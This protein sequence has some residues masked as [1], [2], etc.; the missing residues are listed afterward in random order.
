MTACV[1]IFCFS[2]YICFVILLYFLLYEMWMFD[3]AMNECQFLKK[4]C[5]QVELDFDVNLPKMHKKSTMRNVKLK[6]FFLL[7]YER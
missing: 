6:V 2:S 4:E 7:G 3:C 1:L 5:Q